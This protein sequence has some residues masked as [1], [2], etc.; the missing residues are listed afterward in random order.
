MKKA[1]ALTLALVLLAF[2]AAASAEVTIGDL[3][4]V[5]GRGTLTWTDPDGNGPYKL[6]YH[7]VDPSGCTQC[8]FWAGG[9]EAG[10]TAYGTSYTFTDLAPGRTYELFVEDA[11]GSEVM[12]TVTTPMAYDFTDDRLTTDSVRITLETR[13]ANSS[14]NYR[15][16]GKDFTASEINANSG[17]YYYGV[18]YL[19]EMPRLARPRTYFEQIVFTAPNGFSQT[20]V[21][22]DTTMKFVSARAQFWYNFIGEAFF[23]NMIAKL[24][25]VVP[26]TYTIDLYWDGMFVNRTTF[27]VR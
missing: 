7:Y 22:T 1:I 26:G 14:G 23:S 27:P 3:Q 11:K 9:T 13:Y 17:T 24:G 4:Y 6:A 18:R 8:Y 15:K 5:N 20:V 2:A 19:K 21:A 12:K 25:Q 10:S 16:L